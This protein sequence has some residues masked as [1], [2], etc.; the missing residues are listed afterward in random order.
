[1]KSW[2]RMLYAGACIISVFLSVSTISAYAYDAEVKEVYENSVH[3]DYKAEHIDTT[4]TGQRVVAKEI[5][6]KE[7][8]VNGNSDEEK[9]KQEKISKI[10]QVF[11][12]IG[13]VF[14]IG[15]I[16]AIVLS[17]SYKIYLSRKV[18]PL[19]VLYYGKEE[20]AI[21]E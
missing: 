3:N 17:I 5:S 1:M 16:S 19:P 2:H 11:T 12:F 4:K 20:D 9:K 21:N 14:G 10:K 15:I 7:T 8:D 6:S 13:L 18:V